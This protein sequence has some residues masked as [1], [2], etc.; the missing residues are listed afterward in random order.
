M[1]LGK[2]LDENRCQKVAEIQR[3][4]LS[5]FQF[6]ISFCAALKAGFF[7]EAK[8]PV[9]LNFI[10]YRVYHGVTSNY[11]F[12]RR[13]ESRH[14]QRNKMLRKRDSLCIG[15]KNVSR[16]FVRSGMCNFLND[17]GFVCKKPKHAPGKTDHEKQ[18]EFVAQYRKRY[19]AE[20]RTLINEKFHLVVNKN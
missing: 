15:Y 8:K 17:L 4:V 6:K 10:M 16:F 2:W 1:A 5:W 19:R 9:K 11:R 3:H 18:K 14:F 7:S 12:V 13:A 20:L